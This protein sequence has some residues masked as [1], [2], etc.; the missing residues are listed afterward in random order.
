MS[1]AQT[2]LRGCKGDHYAFLSAAVRAHSWQSRIYRVSYAGFRSELFFSVA[3]STVIFHKNQ[4][5]IC[6]IM[7]LF[8]RPLLDEV[9]FRG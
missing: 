4:T 6:D 1:A 7:C 5:H 8:R 3:C 9:H 2:V